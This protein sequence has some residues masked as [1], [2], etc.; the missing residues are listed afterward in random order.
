MRRNGWSK[1]YERCR[2]CKTSR[3][4]HIAGGYC[5]VCYRLSGKRDAVRAWDL[6]HPETLR[7]YPTDGIF[8]NPR[9]VERLR[10]GF[11][12]Q[13][14]ERLALLRTKEKILTSTVSGRF[15]EIQLRH[16]ARLA[17]SRGADLHHGV[18]ALFDRKFGPKQ[19]ILLYRILLEIEE[20]IPWSGVDIARIYRDVPI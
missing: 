10:K 13:I 17:G 3:R 4:R 18:G 2:N 5:T 14:D 8:H 7:G 20:S 11:L 1:L 9:T 12:K 6:A 16:L 15:L 19:R